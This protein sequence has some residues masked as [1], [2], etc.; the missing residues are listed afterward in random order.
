MINCMLPVLPTE[1]ELEV[2]KVENKK[3]NDKV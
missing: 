2:W 1:I 3:T